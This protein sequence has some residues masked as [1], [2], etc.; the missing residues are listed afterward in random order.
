MGVTPD[1]IAA[2]LA[3]PFTAACATLGSGF[4]EFGSDAILR[5]LPEQ[6]ALIYAQM[7]R[8]GQAVH[9]PASALRAVATYRPDLYDDAAASMAR[10]RSNPTSASRTTGML[11]DDAPFDP[12]RIEDYLRAIGVRSDAS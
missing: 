8:W 3:L 9:A 4:L 10:D 6:A 5:P 7:V 1:V 2:G 12:S 11:F